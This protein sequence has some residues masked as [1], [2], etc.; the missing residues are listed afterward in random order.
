MKIMRC[1]AL[2]TLTVL[3]CLVLLM[4]LGWCSVV[5][6]PRGDTKQD[7]PQPTHGGCCDLCHCGERQH[8]PPAP[9]SPRP[10]TRC[11]CYEQDWLK[12]D[13]PVKAEVGWFPLGLLAVEKQDS[14]AKSSF[15]APDVFTRGPSPPIHVLKC[16]WL[17]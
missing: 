9:E 1:F 16:L 13:L 10:P 12:P 17:C 14:T 11:C 7:T 5:C 6:S 8:P 4:P 2:R 15:A 3:A